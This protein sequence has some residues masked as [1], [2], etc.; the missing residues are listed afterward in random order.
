MISTFTYTVFGTNRPLAHYWWKPIYTA[1]ADLCVQ[2]C[3]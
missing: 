2:C 1:T 3:F